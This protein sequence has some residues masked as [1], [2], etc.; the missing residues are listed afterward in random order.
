MLQA[1]Y[2][3][4][5]IRRRE[6]ATNTERFLFCFVYNLDSKSE[7]IKQT[8]MMARNSSLTLQSCSSKQKAV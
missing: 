8:P 6:G 7:Y 3:Y 4:V 1:L 2:Q 5:R